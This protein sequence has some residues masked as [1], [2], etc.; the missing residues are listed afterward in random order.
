MEEKVSEINSVKLKD[1]ALAS[2]HFYAPKGWIN[3]PNG[4][5]YFN[6]SYRIFFQYNP[7][8]NYWKDI[9]IG[10]AKSKDLLKFDS[11][12]VAL[13]P[14]KEVDGIFSGSVISNEE[15]L[16]LIF[17][18]HIEKPNYRQ[19]SISAGF[20]YDGYNFTTDFKEIVKEHTLPLY[21]T[22]NFRDPYIY[23]EKNTYYLFIAS[24]DK[25]ENLGK[26]I[27]LK[28]KTLDNFEYA[29]E[30]GP[31]E[32][33]G[34]MVECP[35]IGKLGE[36]YILVYS[37][38][39]KDND[40]N[41][42]HTT[43]YLVL[44]MDLEN[45]YFAILTCGELDRSRDFY[46]PQ[47]FATKDNEL[48]MISWLNSYDYDPIE[49]KYDLP[50]CGIY[51]YPRILEIENGELIQKPYKEILKRVKKQYHYCEKEFPVKSM[52]KIQA[53]GEFKI[54]F[55]GSE[56]VEPVELLFYKSKL[57]LKFNDIVSE[58]IKSFSDELTLLILL[59]YTS[60]E[61]FIN[62]GKETLSR[63]VFFGSDSVSIKITNQENIK[64]MI[65]AEL[66]I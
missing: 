61:V 38:I 44:D 66:D 47:L 1:E 8:E 40:G 36:N 48:G 59:D 31:L 46:A 35:A 16:H 11:F 14:N 27:V 25:E 51:S 49:H 22:E 52:L 42:A 9:S 21:D 12:K 30:I 53:N 2:Y 24:K 41:D 34:E 23:K 57:Y 54:E 17:T 7:Y 6:D 62:L 4:I 20:S 43:G 50:T 39:A 58:S 15:G 55:K 26:V 13:A 65:I 18:K 56:N 33:F 37:K 64:N 5:I 60:F 10:V 28:S 29:C 32:V 45:N 3:D 63:R 19:E